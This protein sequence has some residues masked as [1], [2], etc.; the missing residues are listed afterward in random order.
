MKKAVAMVLVVVMM[1]A[2]GVTAFAAR[3]PLTAEQAK[4]VAL[5]YAGVKAADANFTKCHRDYDDGREVYEI[6]FYA[7]NT[8]YDMD[9][10][11]NT[12]RI[13]DFSTE[14]HGGYGSFNTRPAANTQP[15][16]S[17][18]NQPAVNTQPAY[19]YGY[20]DDWDDV[21]DRDWDDRY[22]YDYDWDDRYDYDR[23]FDD[24]FGWDD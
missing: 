1:L 22:D 16:P 8:E 9:V 10:D 24:W 20:Y 23:D 13:T 4:K 12:G 6:E 15:A 5:D 14:Y 7:N 18:R 21:Y 19:G 17:F 11:V 2:L 3:G